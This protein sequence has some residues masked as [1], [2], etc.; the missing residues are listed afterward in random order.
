M[1]NAPNKVVDALSKRDFLWQHLK[2]TDTVYTYFSTPLKSPPRPM[3]STPAIFRMWLICPN[4][5]VMGKLTHIYSHITKN[6]IYEWKLNWCLTDNILNRRIF[7]FT[8][9]NHKTIIE[10]DHYYATIDFL[11]RKNKSITTF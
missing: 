2:G 10:I 1:D 4:K 5:L 8:V 7:F 11:Q 6:I 9:L 3:W